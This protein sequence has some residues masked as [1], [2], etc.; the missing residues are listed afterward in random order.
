MCHKTF[1]LYDARQ[2]GEDREELHVQEVAVAIGPRSLATRIS[3]DL[4][5]TPFSLQLLL[6]FV[7]GDDECEYGGRGLREPELLELLEAWPEQVTWC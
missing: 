2:D 5:L 3:T 4:F 1:K 7:V 6:S